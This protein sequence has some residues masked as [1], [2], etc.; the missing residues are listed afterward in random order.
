MESSLKPYEDSEPYVFVS[1]S[2]EDSD[3]VFPIL[4]RLQAEAIRICYNQGKE[5]NI[6]YNQ[7]EGFKIHYSSGTKLHESFYKIFNCAGVIVFHSKNSVNSKRCKDEI[8][9]ARE[10]ADNKKILSIYLEEVELSIGV[11]MK[12]NRFPSIN[13]Y[14]YDE[15]ER[16]IFYSEFLPK[17]KTLLASYKEKEKTALPTAIVAGSVSAAIGG[18]V[19]AATGAAIGI[20]VA[21]TSTGAS[22]RIPIPFAIAGFFGSFFKDDKKALSSYEGKEPYVFISYSH[23]DSDK[24][25]E[26]IGELRDKGLRFWYDEGIKKGIEWQESIAEHIRDCECTI[27]F[28]SKSSKISEHCKDEIFFARHEFNKKILSVY[29]ESVELDLGIKMSILRFQYMNFYEYAKDKQKFFS[30]LLESPLIQP[31]LSRNK[32]R[33]QKKS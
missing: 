33:Q 9:F 3:K 2:H 14:E 5:F 8:F 10:Q 20:G 22:L 26:I 23:K 15:T 17:L 19:G 29:L 1:Y 32:K 21:G 13:F 4:E 11:M 16:E 18:A 12:I 25:F 27:A 30:E 24:V 6:S 31:C 7:A 28:H